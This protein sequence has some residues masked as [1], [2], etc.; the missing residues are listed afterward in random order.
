MNG[1]YLSRLKIGAA[2]VVLGIA[3]F[4]TPVVA[5]DNGPA[6][7]D[8]GAIIVVTG[9][10]IAR[11]EL[12]VASPIVA[13]TAEAIENTGQTNLVDILIRNPALTASTGSSLAGGA[14]A[15][16]G[17]TG[18]NLLNLRNLG[19]ERTLV[20]V[21]GKRHV[22][23][24]PN[25]AAVDI[26]TIPQELIERVDVLTGGASAIYGADGVS[27]VVNF[28]LKRDFEG[29]TATAQTGISSRGDAAS[30][31]F[32]IIGG[33]NFAGGRGNLTLAYEYNKADRLHSSRRDFTGD[34]AK[35]FTMVRNPQ[36]FTPDSDGKEI[37][38]PNVFD[39]IRQNNLTWAYSAPEG[40]VQLGG[41][42]LFLGD[43]R[44]YDPGI[45]LRGTSFAI[46]GTNTP[47]AGYYGDLQPSTS[48]HSFNIVSGFEFS[49]AARLYIEGKYVT[50][51]AYSVGQP[52][53]EFGTELLVDNPYLLERFGSL[54]VPV[55]YFDENDD[56][57]IPDYNGVA[58]GANIYRDNYDLGIRGETNRRKT[59]RAVIGMEGELSDH[60]RYDVSY[61]FG[62]TTAK[63]SQTNNLIGDRFFAALDAVYD[64]V[65]G[66]NVCRTTLDAGAAIPGLAGG[67]TTF[68]TGTSSIC[69]PLNLLGDGV[70]S[71]EA[72]AFVT[73]D[74]VSR[75]R[76][77]QQV[78]SGYLSGDTGAFFNLP[79]GAVEFAIGAEYREE[80]TRDTP[81]PL[82]VS[83]D[84]RDFSMVAPTS[85]KFDV[86][87][88]FG[89]INLPI[90]KDVPF[91]ERLSLGGA[92]RL[93]DYSTVGSTT[94]WKVDGLYA[95]IKDVRFRATYSQAV[96]APNIGEL[97][98]PTSGTFLRM[99]DPCDINNRNKGTQYRAANCVALLE[100]L[101][102]NATQISSFSP[103]S[104]QELGTTRRGEFS[105]NRDLAEEQ[106]KT[107]TAGVVLQ[108]RFIP[109]LTMTFDWYNTRIKG[110]IN[111]P[112]ATELADL[113][114]DQPTIDNIYCDNLFRETGT[115]YFLGAGD[116]AQKRIAFIVRP[117]NVATFETA[118]AD[119]TV[120]Y[121]LPLS[122]KL[123]R[124][125]FNLTGGYLDKISFV[126]TLGADL[127]EDVLESY[128]PRW[129]GNA[130]LTWS[131]QNV[132]VNYGVN[133]WSKTRR[134][135]TETLAGEPDISDPKYFFVKRK[136]EHDIRASVSVDERFQFF[137]GV[138]NLYNEKPSFGELSYPVSA[139]GRYF[140]FGIKAGL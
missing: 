66:Q 8:N 74:N 114:V 129:R 124:L 56:P 95:P 131:L 36:D 9:S 11:P 107:W 134:Y 17:Y 104:I 71:P 69:R 47:V 113:C 84:F 6:G 58:V 117:D 109:G 40:M 63:F 39:Q 25:T 78:V 92:V 86:K 125:N 139:I 102:L 1:T 123:G 24:V 34:P 106:A 140:Y 68:T 82:L 105:G 45:V 103:S 64:P 52:S 77:T 15:S 20:L 81:D 128:N 30:Q 26:N 2:P 19:S 83:G 60:L 53:F 88:V 35:Y 70:A 61:V 29:L 13:V 65:S 32:A 7:I 28:I 3:L 16:Y 62:R 122:D 137:G 48:R 57:Y 33:K 115:G 55:T 96:R 98:Q 132:S 72:L 118:G 100:G 21:N 85:G 43:G 130:S 94:T 126:P 49:P 108:P 46:G 87:E 112:T 42:G 127:D 111:T 79:G 120:N 18:V 44:D 27:G 97:F 133:Y 138:N 51:K 76:I 50:S 31:R 4:S 80:K 93:S 110:A 121:V 5:Q 54:V 41:G 89:E 116:D 90:L 75:S 37:D 91:A 14:D 101:G 136:M 23:G 99:V 119:F 135:T 67:P 38:D 10:R 73:A 22:A 12:E 59:F